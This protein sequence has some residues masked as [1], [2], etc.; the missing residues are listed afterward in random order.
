MIQLDDD[1]RPGNRP[2]DDEAQDGHAREEDTS[3]DE[4]EDEEDDPDDDPS[5]GGT[6]PQGP[7]ILPE[8]DAELYRRALSLVQRDAPDKDVAVDVLNDRITGFLRSRAAFPTFSILMRMVKF[9]K[10]DAL[11]ADY[12]PSPGSRRDMG[13]RLS[14]DLAPGRE[15]APSEVDNG[16]TDLAQVIEWG[17]A[18][19]R[20]IY[21][22]PARMSFLQGRGPA[23]IAKRLDS[24]EAR[25]RQQLHRARKMLAAIL[26]QWALPRLPE[27]C[28]EA[29]R[30]HHVEGN[31]CPEIAAI[32][33]QSKET[34]ELW[35]SD[36]NKTLVN[37]FNDSDKL[38]SI[39]S[40]SLRGGRLD[41]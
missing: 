18:Q 2:G 19:L 5:G 34:I 9:T 32:L 20:P 11:R 36:G 10:L 33:Q 1:R 39:L 30:L 27:R 23:Q 3:R 31:S 41:S 13:T 14:P 22:E 8:A 4:N 40:Q 29:I 28:R 15:P 21:R 7:W 6:T 26:V 12:S 35:L 25:V 17:I 38:Q 37:L 16:P 24:T